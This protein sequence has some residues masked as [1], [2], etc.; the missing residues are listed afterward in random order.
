MLL[1]GLQNRIAGSAS[2]LT[3]IVGFLLTA[4][5]SQ[6]PGG[7]VVAGIKMLLLDGCYKIPGLSLGF[8]MAG[9]GN[10]A[11]FLNFIAGSAILGCCL[12]DMHN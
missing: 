12:V 8:H 3:I 5:C 9:I 10:K 11:G 6:H 7:A 2:R 4:I 1:D